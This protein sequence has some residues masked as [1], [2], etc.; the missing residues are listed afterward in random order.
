MNDCFRQ[1]ASMLLLRPE[2]NGDLRI[3]LLHK[4]RKRDA[5]QLPQGGVEEGESLVECAERELQEEAGISGVK[6]L[7]QSQLVYEYRFPA[8]YRRFRPDHICGQH[9]GFVFA[10]A[11]AGATVT[12]DDNEVDEYVWIRQDEL[13]KYL[14]RKEYLSLVE[15]LVREALQKQL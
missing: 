13:S 2:E 9:I 1:A 6:I 11:P 8:S 5:W 10:V 14:K 7:G 15:K 3:L 12:V 4:P